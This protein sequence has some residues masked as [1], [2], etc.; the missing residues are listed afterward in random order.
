MC[1]NMTFRGCFV[2]TMLTRV[3]DIS[4]N[5]IY[6][7]FKT[8]L[9]CCFVITMF[10]RVPDISMNRINVCFKVMFPC[11]LVITMFTRVPDISSF[12]HFASVCYRDIWL[13][14]GTQLCAL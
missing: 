3:T 10:T 1:F 8:T 11:C 4:M 13:D 5:R 6:M 12:L 9:L 7:C 2:I 14:C